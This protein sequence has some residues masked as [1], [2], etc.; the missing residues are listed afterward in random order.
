[1]TEKV[2]AEMMKV[3]EDG[4]FDKYDP[5]NVAPLIVYLCSESSSHVNGHCF[6]SFGGKLSIANGWKTGDVHDKGARYEV[7]EMADLVDKLMAESPPAQP[8]YGA[9]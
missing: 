8:V 4:S 7:S 9:S 3:P 2:F 5:A 6:E 1:M